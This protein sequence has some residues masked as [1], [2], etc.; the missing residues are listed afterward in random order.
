[1][2]TRRSAVSAAAAEEE[3]PEETPAPKSVSKEPKDESL[4]VEVCANTEIS[5][6]SLLMANRI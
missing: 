1:M 2:P 5:E 6:N 3:T 4:N